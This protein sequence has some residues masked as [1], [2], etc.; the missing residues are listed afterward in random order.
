MADT[1]LAPLKGGIAVA[2]Y[3]EQYCA[4]WEAFVAQSQQGTLFH[5]RA[6]LAYHP[7][8]RFHDASLLFFKKE[9]LL[10]VFPAAFV[11]KDSARALV[12]HPGASF[13][14]F[15]AA[16]PLSL[17]EREELAA[18]LVQHAREHDCS[19]I[20]LTL[21]PLC[22]QPYAEQSLDYALWRAG[23]RDQR[24]ELTQA[25]RLDARREQN[26]S[27]EFQRKIRR[28]QTLGVVVRESEDL[29]S[30]YEI[31]RRN[32][33]ARH[34]ARPTHTLEELLDLRQ[35]LPQRI[36]LFAAYAQE[37]MIAGYLLFVCNAQAALAF[38]IGQL[39]EA[40]HYRAVN[41]LAHETMNWCEREG[42]AY[43][44]FGTST[45]NAEPN[46]GLVDFREA[47]GARGFWRE[48][49]RLVLG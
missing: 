42:L 26:Y 36:R 25:V 22:Y 4:Q 28:G 45:I 49:L 33:A 35:R 9:K 18:S 34:G 17:R 23:F 5:T 8:E 16:Q 6:F 2:K 12:S 21:P 48:R 20:E 46:W 37:K 10:A 19:A 38:Y 43:F 14:G 47:A 30:F 29:Q 13:G 44:D 41:L 40:Q 7:A 39:Y 15:V 11:E 31:L 24:R 32:L 1:P 27:A 3:S